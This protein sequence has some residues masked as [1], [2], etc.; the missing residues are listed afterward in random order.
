MNGFKFPFI[1]FYGSLYIIWVLGSGRIRCY[2]CVV[3]ILLQDV[4]IGYRL[5]AWIALVSLLR[6][7]RS[8]SA[9]LL[10][11]PF[12]YGKIVLV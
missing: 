5:D 1:L 3:V 2:C 4:G 12:I 11:L 7:I 6:S 10:S 8:A 9:M